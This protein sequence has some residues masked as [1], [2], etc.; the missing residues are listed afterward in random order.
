M[1]VPLSQRRGALAYLCPPKQGEVPVALGEVLAD[2][3]GA[4]ALRLVGGLLL[5]RVFPLS[6]QAQRGL[7]GL[8][9]GPGRHR[10]RG[11]GALLPGLRAG[12]L[13]PAG[14]ADGC[15]GGDVSARV[16][17][18]GLCQVGPRAGRPGGGRGAGSGTRG[19]RRQAPL[20]AGP[21]SPP[22]PSCTCAMSGQTAP[23]CA[24]PRATRPTPVPAAM[25][26]LVLP[27]PVGQWHHTPIP[28]TCPPPGKRAC[29][30][31]LPLGGQSK[32]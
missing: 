18:P 16:G 10:P 4:S 28:C 20:P 29:R 15:P 30:G 8:R 5:S 24:R 21:R 25:E 11:P 32:S 9:A 17:G 7:V 19:G 27:L 6:P 14:S 31:P 3:G 1:G 12:L 13:R 23:S 26:T 22:R 2:G